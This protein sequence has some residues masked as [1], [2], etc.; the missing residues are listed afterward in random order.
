MSDAVSLIDQY[1]RDRFCHETHT[2]FVVVAPAGVGKTTAI[3][4]RIVAIALEELEQAE[5]VLPRLALVTYTRKAAE[6]MRER[7]LSELAKRRASPELIG[8]VA[9]AFFGTLHSY[10]LDLIHEFGPAIGLSTKLE[11]TRNV[12]GL[13]LDYKRA[14]GDFLRDLPEAART[15]FQQHATLLKALDIA[16]TLSPDT[17][18]PPLGPFRQ[19]DIASLLQFDDRKQRSKAAIAEGKRLAQQWQQQASAGE[20]VSI[21]EYTKGGKDFQAAWQACFG[22]LSDWLGVATLHLAAQ[23]A[24]DF[25]NYRLQMGQIGYSDMSVLA[26]RLVCDPVAGRQIRQQ[27]RCVILDEAQDTDRDQFRVL[28]GVTAPPE[29]QSD[30]LLCT[31]LPPGRFCMVGDPQQSIYSDRAD[32]PTYRKIGDNLARSGSAEALI[33]EV[34]MRC[35]AAVVAQ[36]NA[37]FATVF[38]AT[39]ALGQVAYVPLEARPDAIGGAV[40]RL[41]LPDLEAASGEA[42]VAAGVA[43]WLAAQPLETL[44]ANDANEVALLCPRNDWLDTLAGAMQAHGLS[45]QRHSTRETQGSLPPYAW[46]AGLLHCWQ[47]P[48]DGFE[49]AG[50]LQEIMGHSDADIAA[51]RRHLP[52]DDQ[53]RQLRIDW[54][55]DTTQPVG[56]SLNQLHQLWRETHQTAA[57]ERFVRISDDLAIPA[58]LHALQPYYAVDLSLAWLRIGE[59]LMRMDTAGEGALAAVPWLRQVHESELEAERVLP[60]HFQLL[61]NYK[62]KGLEWPVVIM[63]FLFQKLGTPNAQFPRLIEASG[64]EP[65][66]VAYNKLHGHRAQEQHHKAQTSLLNQRLCYVACT[67]AKRHLILV[68]DAVAY[69]SDSGSQADAMGF[70]QN[71][72]NRALWEALPRRASVSPQAAT[73]QHEV[74]SDTVVAAPLS[75]TQRSALGEA[76]TSVPK[77]VLPSSLA[78]HRTPAH[79]ERDHAAEPG[80]PENLP[81]LQA[82]EGA[83]YGNWWHD[84]MEHAPWHDREALE[85]WWRQSL[86]KCPLQERGQ[87]ELDGFRQSERYPW[88]I[89]GPHQILTEV[90]FLWHHHGHVYDGFIDLVVMRPQACLVIDWKTDRLEPEAIRDSYAPQLMCYRDAL[91]AM[92]GLPTTVQCYSTVAAQWLT[93]ERQP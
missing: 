21:P 46:A 49:L 2:N 73:S 56:Q 53:L 29:Y 35:P 31:D 5:P 20:S 67:R 17:Q 8:R 43:Q 3:V 10:C 54:P 36:V 92:T 68:D 91:A 1:A 37:S 11:L 60:G 24:R 72:V 64:D 93:I 80:F 22:P 14:H 51:Y 34:T 41:P 58:R 25:L 89:D 77:R 74:D 88:L 48:D 65:V 23:V 66:R 13:W 87:T 63:P 69:K 45:V 75:E 83:N 30:P 50:I 52:A 90:P 33:F 9:Q 12:D 39:Q 85:A 26:A 82:M 79:R 27:K 16:K 78:T 44:G 4:R 62:A 28:L 76:L 40:T 15:P 19:P 38:S 32:L 59:A 18:P 7:T 42:A 70:T 81:E 57:A 47:F 61:T 84:T 6:E 55:A 86:A 71:G